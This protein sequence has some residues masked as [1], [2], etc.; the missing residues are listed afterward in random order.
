MVITTKAT[1]DRANIKP[2]PPSFINPAT[3]IINEMANITLENLIFFY[4]H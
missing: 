3:I 4:K 1:N 2:D